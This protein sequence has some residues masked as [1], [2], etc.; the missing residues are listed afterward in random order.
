MPSMLNFVAKMTK[1]LNRILVPSEVL[2]GFLIVHVE[3]KC[4]LGVNAG[5]PG[6]QRQ[7]QQ[8]FIT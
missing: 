2:F 4:F 1:T 7:L 3:D 5:I 8:N 6:K